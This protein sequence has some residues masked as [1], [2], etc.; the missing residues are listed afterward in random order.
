MPFAASERPLDETD[1]CSCGDW[2]AEVLE[3]DVVS[4]FLKQRFLIPKSQYSH[5][6]LR[7]VLSLETSTSPFGNTGAGKGL[8]VLVAHA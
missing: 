7:A 2:G 5:V 3:K 1:R 8:G 4:L 6:A